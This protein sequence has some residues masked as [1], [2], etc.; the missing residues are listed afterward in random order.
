MKKI[1]LAIQL[2]I[3][4]F[5][6]LSAQYNNHIY[7]QIGAGGSP[8]SVNYD[9]YF[10]K[11]TDANLKCYARIGVGNFDFSETI[12]SKF[13]PGTKSYINS[14]SLL[15]NIFWYSVFSTKDQ[16]IYRNQNFDVNNLFLGSKIVLG[17]GAFNLEMGLNSRFDFVKQNIDAWENEPA[18]SQRFTKLTFVPSAVLKYSFYNFTIRGGG[19]LHKTYGKQEGVKFPFFAGLGFQF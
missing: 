12:G 9:R 3:L 13:I 4:S 5:T 17:S 2:T 19:E 8:N 16:T 7:M 1:L 6:L 10:Y 18:R 15:L 11:S 14:S